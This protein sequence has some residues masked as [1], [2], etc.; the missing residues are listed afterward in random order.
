MRSP[1]IRPR[2][3]KP[4]QAT[5]KFLY[6]PAPFIESVK[7]AEGYSAITNVPSGIY[8]SDT[9]GSIITITGY[10]FF[11][12]GLD[13]VYFG[14]K[15][16][17]IVEKY[18]NKLGVRVPAIDPGDTEIYVRSPVTG[19][20]ST[21]IPFKVLGPPVIQNQ[22]VTEAMAGESIVLTGDNLHETWVSVKDRWYRPDSAQKSRLTF[23]MPTVG[24]R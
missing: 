9:G 2:H 11:F 18:R 20:E 15:Q 6:D 17:T 24:R 12:D 13:Y 14:D 19:K 22:N 10:E 1:S 3:K 5:L 4:A 7:P 23:R 21:H 8:I 16:G